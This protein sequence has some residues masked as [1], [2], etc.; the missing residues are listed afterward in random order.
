M[1]TTVPI[2]K[3]YLTLFVELNVRDTRIKFYSERG[4]LIEMVSQS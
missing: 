3:I 4:S 2:V 1:S